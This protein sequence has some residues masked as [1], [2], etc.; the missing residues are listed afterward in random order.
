[1]QKRAHFD[2]KPTVN[3]IFRGE[4]PLLLPQIS[5]VRTY[6]R[7]SVR[8]YVRLSVRHTTLKFL[9]GPSYEKTF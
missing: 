1:M 6:V 9:V 2:L 7:P 4:G 5:K 8:T 3:L